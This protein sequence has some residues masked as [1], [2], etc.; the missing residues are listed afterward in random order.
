G[1]IFFV[2][3]TATDINLTG[4]SITN[5]DAEGNFLRAEA[6]GWGNEGSNGG[7]V[8]LN[9]S[10]QTI[11]G[12]IIVDD[13]SVLNMYL[14]DKSSFSG[15]INTDGQKGDV[16]VEIEDG[17]TWTL[18]ADS[19]VSGLTV[20]KVSAIDLNGH[21]LYV[22]GKE[23]TEGSASEGTAFEVKTES[24]GSGAPEGMP[25]DGQTPPD[26]GQGGPGSGDG[27]GKPSGNP[28]E[29]P[30]GDNG[31]EPPAKPGSDSAA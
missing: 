26:G 10:A 20:S 19:Y 1:D 24:G 12:N 5:E 16:Y 14:K 15:A 17:S 28:P 31:G 22:D 25:G 29:K 18:T 8:N 23:Y 27:S 7:K 4:V 21:K 30:S 3:N 6:A 9:A 13:V 2:N 11:E